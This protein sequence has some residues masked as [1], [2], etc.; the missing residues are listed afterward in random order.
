MAFLNPFHLE[1]VDA[2]E[3]VSGIL[4][5]VKVGSKDLLMQLDH[6]LGMEA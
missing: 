4:A 6:E 1:Q 3:T 2:E 5:K